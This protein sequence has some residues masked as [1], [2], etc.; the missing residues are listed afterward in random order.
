MKPLTDPPLPFG[1]AMP[2]YFSMGSPEEMIM[3][4]MNFSRR[5]I[6]KLVLAGVPALAGLPSAFAQG[7]PFTKANRSYLQGIQ[8]G[9]Q[10]F[11]Y[12]DLPMTTENRP[13]LVKR[14]VQNGMGVVEL[15][16]VWCEPRFDTPGVSA[17]EARD[18]I[19]DWRINTRAD[20]FRKIK[21]E[22][23]DAGI[24]IASYWTNVN[25]TH[26]DA[27]IDAIF[28]AAK[29]L[30]CEGVTGSYGIEISRRLVPFPEKHGLYVGLH[31]HDNLSDPD[32][33][34][35]EASFMKGLALSPHFKA[36]LDVR[37][38][39]A[40]NGDCVGFLERH[41]DRMCSVHLGDRRRNNGRSAPFGEGDSPLIEILQL[42]R[43]NQWPLITLLEFEHGTLRT[44]V[45]E[46]KLMFDYC[47]RAIEA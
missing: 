35:N 33:Y 16:A 28:R 3:K 20:Y 26:T 42:L 4:E 7:K 9:L 34:S 19:R 8:F 6:G 45:E 39:T 13:T 31:N 15:H 24:T 23:D 21:K 44:G 1:E 47:K 5:D 29:T 10:P 38:F 14:L 41:H 32:A 36:I 22:F 2:L 18:K 40:G 30:G 46:V 12:H 25:E 27:E 11:C 37:H 17:K 43:E